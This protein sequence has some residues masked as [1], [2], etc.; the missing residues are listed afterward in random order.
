MADASIQDF[1]YET[2]YAKWTCLGSETEALWK[3]MGVDL[4]RSVPFSVHSRLKDTHPTNHRQVDWPCTD[5]QGG[6]KL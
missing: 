6:E 2:M 1:M 4:A 5:L 3:T